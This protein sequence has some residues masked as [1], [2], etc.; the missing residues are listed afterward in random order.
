MDAPRW[1]FQPD[2]LGDA[3][4]Y[5]VPREAM[6]SALRDLPLAPGMRVL[7][8][9]CGAGGYTALLME[10][11]EGRGAWVAIDH[12]PDLLRQARENVT[13]SVPTRFERG[14]ALALPFAEGEFDAVVSAFLLCV[15]P[16]PLAALREMRRVTRPGGVIASISCFCKSGALPLFHGVEQW[17]GM[18]RYAE[19]EPRVRAAFRQG[20]RNPGL[21]LPSGRDL[22][23]WGD[24][25]AAGLV[26]LRMTGYLTVYAPADSRW[27]D[28]DARDWL[29]RRERVEANLFERLAKEG[30]SKL[31]PWGVTP[32]EVEE[33]RLL[34]QRRYAFLRGEV[35]RHRRNLDAMADP[36]VLIVGRVPP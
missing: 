6:E 15:L 22:D 4:R 28:E 14:D 35:G 34:T 30:V 13:P 32:D 10:K 12:D 9:G 3:A 27:S 8:V 18:A 25:A 29:A 21:G 5:R 36:N 33:L 2:G 23:V 26:D 16:S 31:A 20:V 11:L 7:E 17:D 19:L 24:Y 1:R